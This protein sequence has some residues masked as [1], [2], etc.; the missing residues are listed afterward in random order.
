[1]LM[2][3]RLPPRMA[4]VLAIEN[5]EKPSPKIGPR[6]PHVDFLEGTDETFLHEIV[7]APRVTSQSAREAL[8]AWNYGQNFVMQMFVAKGRWR[9]TAPHRAIRVMAA[10]TVVL[11]RQEHANTEK[12]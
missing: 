1:M 9:E 8:K 12:G 11:I 2:M 5:C 3:T 4:D 6:L 10:T 7:G